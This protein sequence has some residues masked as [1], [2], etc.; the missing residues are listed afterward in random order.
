MDA[1]GRW[2][3]PG[4]PTDACGKIR[5][6]VRDA[7]ANLPLTDVSKRTL[8]EM[9]SGIAD[10]SGCRQHSVDVVRV[11]TKYGEERWGT[12]RG[13]ELGDGSPVRLC[14]YRV[15]T[16]ERHRARPNGD[17]ERGAMLSARQWDTIKTTMRKAG[18]AR[19]CTKLAG[20]FA[21]LSRTDAADGAVYIELDGCRRIVAVPDVGGLT[22]AQADAALVKLLDAAVRAG[23]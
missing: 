4:L 20:R 1:Q 19:D 22:L 18:G 9:V 2:I 14:L 7:V 17:F 16:G 13:D 23:R 3:R 8:R 6:E 10:A 11:H 21:L 12:Y 5:S 15:S